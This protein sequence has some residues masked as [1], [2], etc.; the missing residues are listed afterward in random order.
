M[1]ELLCFF[2]FK[3]LNFLK[4]KAAPWAPGLGGG[5]GGSVSHGD[6]VSV[7]EDGMFWRQAVGMVAQHRECA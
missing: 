1:S 3:K 7:W 5:A 6:R 4:K 2:S